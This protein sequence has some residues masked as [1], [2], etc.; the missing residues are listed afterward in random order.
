[1]KLQEIYEKVDELAPF[2]LSKEWIAKGAY[3]NS[4]IIVDIGGEINQVLFALD[5]TK[6][7]FEAAKR[8]NANCIV[9]H[10]PAIYAPI[11]TLR[12]DSLIL[13][14]AETGIS[15]LSAHLNLDAAN[16]GIDESLMEGLG[17]KNA[18]AIMQHLTGGGYGRVYDV[19]AQSLEELK[20]YAEQEFRSKRILTYGNAPVKR[21][22]SFCGGGFDEAAI[23]FALEHGADTICSSDSKHHL[24]TA[25]LEGGLNILLF[26]HYASEQ[27]GF[28][29]FFLR[30]KEALGVPCEYFAEERFL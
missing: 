14:C 24:I 21:I 17:G 20:T 25:A 3:D 9:T 23:S 30:M 6:E 2:A 7:S 12:Q 13:K 8:V 1:M 4:G 28:H 19:K 29:R 15:V 5:L 10:H 16:G 26:T 27:Y 18:L 22:A 11:R